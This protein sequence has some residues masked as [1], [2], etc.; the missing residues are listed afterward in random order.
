MTVWPWPAP[1]DDGAARHLVRGRAVPDFALPATTGEYVSLAARKGRTVLFFYPWTGRPGLPDPP[2]WDSIAGAHGSTAE[3]EGFRD[4]QS[5]F[6]ALD[7]TVVGVSTQSADYQRE[8]AERVKL[9]YALASDLDFRLSDAL[10][11]PTFETGGM[12]F[13][14]RLT[15][16]LLDGR[17]EQVFYPV[18]PPDTHAREVLAWLAARAGCGA[19]ERPRGRCGR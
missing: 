5:A 6:A 10:K 11:L 4:L 14:K 7:T 19:E 3:A 12:R 1:A 18:H 2:G 15:V 8:L 9:N 13:L 16:V 17:I